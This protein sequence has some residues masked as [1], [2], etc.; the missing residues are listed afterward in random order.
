M[1]KVI[2]SKK[3][4]ASDLMLL[5][6]KLL[7]D[8]DENDA[9]T[10]HFYDFI[11][12]SFTFGVFVD[13]SR[14]MDQSVYEKNF[15]FS[16]RPT[17]GGVL[18]HQWDFAFSCLVP[19][20]HPAYLEDVMSSYQY[21][22]QRIVFALKEFVE[23]E[24]SLQRETIVP[25][26]ESCN[27]F[28]FSKPTRYDIMLEGKKIAGAAQRRVRNGYLHQGSIALI[29]P[30]YWSLEPLFP[31]ESKVLKAMNQ[32]SA[33]LLGPFASPKDRWDVAEKIKEN[34]VNCLD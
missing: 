1:W 14:L 12:P 32:N 11:K 21:I 23:G 8:L 30:K 7:A 9:P 28:C 33:A 24:F 29:T 25:E 26:E 19:K 31:K 18:F 22:N 10:I 6:A 34:I 15:D 3:R 27:H 20:N 5:D 13:P 16:K 4:S 2:D 17:G